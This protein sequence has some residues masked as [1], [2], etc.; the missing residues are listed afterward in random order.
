MGT[1]ESKFSM[2]F[3]KLKTT[4]CN[5]ESFT[6]YGKSRKGTKSRA[7]CFPYFF[8]ELNQGCPSQGHTLCSPPGVPQSPHTSAISRSL[9][10]FYLHNIPCAT[11]WPP[12]AECFVTLRAEAQQKLSPSGWKEGQEEVKGAECSTGW[13]LLSVTWAAPE[14]KQQQPGQGLQVHPASIQAR[15]ESAME[16]VDVWGRAGEIPEERQKRSS[17]KGVHRNWRC[18]G[19]SRWQVLSQALTELLLLSNTLCDARER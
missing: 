18:W 4:K 7:A 6:T 15:E 5:E 12:R 14:D 3:K 16:A 9:Q 8:P 2:H 1:F 11:M 17:M 13:W 19:E 10:S